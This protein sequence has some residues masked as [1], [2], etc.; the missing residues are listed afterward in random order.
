[1]I[2][3]FL[4]LIFIC[5]AHCI[6]QQL[7]LLPGVKDFE[8]GYDAVKMR[9]QSSKFPLFDLTDQTYTSFVMNKLDQQRSYT[10]PAMIQATDISLRREIDCESI[11]YDFKQ[12]YSR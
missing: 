7:P 2:E 9:E 12:F 5:F 10:V 11:S 3:K 8:L 4:I 6:A 1:M